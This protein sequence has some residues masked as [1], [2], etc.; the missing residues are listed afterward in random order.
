MDRTIKFN[1]LVLGDIDLAAIFG[2]YPARMM[3]FNSRLLNKALVSRMR[4]LLLLRKSNK[5]D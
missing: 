5:W 3:T 4:I 2:I 1:T